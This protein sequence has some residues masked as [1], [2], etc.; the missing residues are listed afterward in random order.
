MLPMARV[1]PPMRG[2]SI[3]SQKTLPAVYVVGAVNC[4]K[5]APK[6]LILYPPRLGR[7]RF[8]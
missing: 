6:K 2:K 4:I 5:T 1:K 8:H 3:L 7:L